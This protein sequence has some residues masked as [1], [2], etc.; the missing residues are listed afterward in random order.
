MSKPRDIS[1]SVVETADGLRVW[2]TCF[3]LKGRLGPKPGQQVPEDVRRE[4][5]KRVA[6]VLAQVDFGVLLAPEGPEVSGEEKS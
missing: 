1:V 4:I 3:T 6:T 5:E 2:N